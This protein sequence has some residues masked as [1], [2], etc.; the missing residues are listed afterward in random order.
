MLVGSARNAA[1][2]MMDRQR[3]ST[4]TSVISSPSNFEHKKLDGTEASNSPAT[5]S[6][7]PQVSS[8]P[9]ILLRSSTASA[10]INREPKKKGSYRQSMV[11]KNPERAEDAEDLEDRDLERTQVIRILESCNYQAVREKKH[12]YNTLFTDGT[13]FGKAR[14]EVT[15]FFV[16]GIAA[17]SPESHS[18]HSFCR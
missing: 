16:L 10:E 6:S 4:T 5:P 14:E 12:N 15:S 1:S 9:K 11:V 8:P 3:T 18:I 2:S 13:L 7:T 17:A